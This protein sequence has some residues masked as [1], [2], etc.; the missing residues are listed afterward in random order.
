MSSKVKAIILSGDGINCELESKHAFIL[1]GISAEIIHIQE[2]I[3]GSVKLSNYHILC[4]PGGF[5]F[6]DEIKSGKI[7]A[8]KIQQYLKEEFD[9]FHYSKKPIIGICNGFQALTYLGVFDNSE[10]Q[11]VS[12]DEN[13]SGKFQNFWV[14]LKINAQSECIWTK[15]IENLRLP[16]RH[17]EGKV[18]FSKKTDSN[19]SKKAALFYTRDIN[20]SYENIAGLTCK[21]GTTL[22]LMPHPEAGLYK[23]LDPTNSIFNFETTQALKL[24]KNAK[25]YVL[26]KD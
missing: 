13:V 5:S 14:D 12:L 18:S 26:S 25:Q 9:E 7:L 19:T 1:A 21:Y 20:G 23:M 11:S 3:Q 24:F 17:G 4:L 2:L 22:G 10:T 8:L 6:G 15:G 16:I